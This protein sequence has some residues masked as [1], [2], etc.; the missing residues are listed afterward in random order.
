[1]QVGKA[2]CSEARIEKLLINF[3]DMARKTMSSSPHYKCDSW[4]HRI[5]HEE[6]LYTSEKY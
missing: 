1:M 3:P 4:N 2:S 5:F 6:A